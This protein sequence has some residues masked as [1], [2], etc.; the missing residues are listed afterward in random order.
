MKVDYET[1]LKLYDFTK[2]V[3]IQF[4][5]LSESKLCALNMLYFIL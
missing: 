3:V 2:K 5:N 1:C 4:K